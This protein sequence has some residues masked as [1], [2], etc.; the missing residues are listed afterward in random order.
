MVRKCRHCGEDFEEPKPPAK[1]FG[2]FVDECSECADARYRPEPVKE[3]G[4]QRKKREVGEIL[5]RVARKNGVPPS[6]T[7][8]AMRVYWQDDTTDD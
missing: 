4:E 5:E 8:E 1:P 7:A 2:K 6:G 3:T